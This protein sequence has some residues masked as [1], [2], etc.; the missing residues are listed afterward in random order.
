MTDRSFIL[1][2]LRMRI[3][4]DYKKLH[5]Q[6]YINKKKERKNERKKE[7]FKKSIRCTF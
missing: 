3:K 7:D 2:M 1:R 6:T 4:R 5:I